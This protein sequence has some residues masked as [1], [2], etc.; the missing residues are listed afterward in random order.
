MSSL[1]AW[2]VTRLPST[3]QAARAAARAEK[4]VKAADAAAA[5][6]AAAQEEVRRANAMAE[7]RVRALALE[8]GLLEEIEER[9]EAKVLEAERKLSACTADAARRLDEAARE[10]GRLQEERAAQ[11]TTCV[12]LWVMCGIA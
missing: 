10:I 1:H 7:V 4:A 8:L 11:V 12:P 6:E 3:T 9:A 5:A 2:L